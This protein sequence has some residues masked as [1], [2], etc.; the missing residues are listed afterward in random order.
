MFLVALCAAAASP[1]AAQ[2]MRPLVADCAPC[3]GD[4]GVA[5][6]VEVPNLA[7]QRETYLYNQLVAFHRGKRP[8]KEMRLMSRHMSE[9]EMRAIAQYYSSLPPR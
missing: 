6:D 9:K 1:A 7:G 4:E 5:K 8:H 3:H 2:Q